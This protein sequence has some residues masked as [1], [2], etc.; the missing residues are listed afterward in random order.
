MDVDVVLGML[1]L[2]LAWI[3]N[4]IGRLT[5]DADGARN[6]LQNAAGTVSL[7][8]EAPF[9]E[10]P[11]ATWANARLEQKRVHVQAN[12]DHG[13]HKST[14]RDHLYRSLT[15]STVR[16]YY[17]SVKQKE[18][19]SIFES[20][21][22]ISL[23]KNKRRLET[24]IVRPQ[25]LAE[26]FALAGFSLPPSTPY[27]QRKLNHVSISLTREAFLNQYWQSS[28]CGF[29]HPPSQLVSFPIRIWIATRVGKRFALSPN[30]LTAPAS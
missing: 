15:I 12:N 2:E 6:R 25:Y 17:H 5:I 23:P 28:V 30:S 29:S 26:S 20:T 8:L 21:D 10:P 9:E 3:P 14:G 19:K 18:V 7:S 1:T 4:S 22:D 11:G 27:T 13:S 24:P 16:H